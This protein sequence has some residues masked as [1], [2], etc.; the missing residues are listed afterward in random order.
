MEVRCFS[1]SILKIFCIS[2]RNKI[3]SLIT[4][5]FC[6]L[7]V[8]DLFVAKA[9]SII[10]SVSTVFL[11]VNESRT[12]KIADSCLEVW[13][14][15]TQETVM[16]QLQQ[17]SLY[18]MGLLPDTETCGSRMW[19]EWLERF[20]FFTM[21]TRV[22]AKTRLLLFGAPDCLPFGCFTPHP[23]FYLEYEISPKNNDIL[24]FPIAAAKIVIF[25]YSLHLIYTCVCLIISKINTL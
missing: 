20:F 4:F 2:F 8:S 12:P 19:R 22:L 5:I 25:L 14:E 7:L 23:L 3:T 6:A 13:R 18:P 11:G 9:F 15:L 21:I 1:G 17:V 16:L 10:T 24:A